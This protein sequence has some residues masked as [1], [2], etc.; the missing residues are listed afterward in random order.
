MV[1][2]ISFYIFILNCFVDVD[3]GMAD[4]L[5]VASVARGLEREHR[6]LGA[7]ALCDSVV[8]SFS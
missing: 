3:V 5:V 6:L 1:E 2:F 4:E 8:R 7:A